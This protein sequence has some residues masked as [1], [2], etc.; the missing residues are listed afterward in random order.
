MVSP[1]QMPDDLLWPYA[2]STNPTYYDFPLQYVIENLLGGR[3]NSNGFLCAPDFDLVVSILGV[4]TKPLSHYRP[5]N[6]G[7]VMRVCP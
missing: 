2:M 3:H 4:C 5:L 7:A 6:C 1:G